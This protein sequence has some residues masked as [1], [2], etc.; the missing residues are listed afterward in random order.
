MKIYPPINQCWPLRSITINLYCVRLTIS[1]R[2]LCYLNVVHHIF[3]EHPIYV[4]YVGCCVPCRFPRVVM[5]DVL[6]RTLFFLG[7]TLY[8][9]IP[10][11]KKTNPYYFS[12]RM[13]HFRFVSLGRSLVLFLHNYHYFVDFVLQFTLLN[14]LLLCEL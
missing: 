6:S 10:N 4:L 12:I 9:T 7:V 11:K 5:L 8:R 13:R 3:Y 1:F 2:R 14:Y